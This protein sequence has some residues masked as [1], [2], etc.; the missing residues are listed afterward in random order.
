MSL[1]VVNVISAFFC[2]PRSSRSSE[3]SGAP[4][5][6]FDDDG[7]GIE[8]GSSVYGSQYSFCT[9]IHCDNDQTN[10]KINPLFGR[11]DLRLSFCER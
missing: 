3:D 11:T 10:S 8:G 6:F 2:R 5:S 7:F 1:F 4:R 9:C